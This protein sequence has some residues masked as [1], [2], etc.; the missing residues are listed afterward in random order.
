VPEVRERQRG[1]DATQRQVK[2]AVFMLE[3]AMRRIGTCAYFPQ[4]R[5]ASEAES[6]DSELLSRLLPDAFSTRK[7][8]ID[9]LSLKGGTIM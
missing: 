6:S 7:T 4:C 8:G 3:P 9:L 5:L 1:L 2:F